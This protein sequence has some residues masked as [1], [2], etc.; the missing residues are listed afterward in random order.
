MLETKN[1]L[2]QFLLMQDMQF[3]HK[4]LFLLVK[5]RNQILYAMLMKTDPNILV[6]S[7][8][9]SAFVKISRIESRCVTLLN[10][11]KI[12]ESEICNYYSKYSFSGWIE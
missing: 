3:P 2:I 11:C 8:H 9:S 12:R 6:F 7:G 10:N 1:W 5:G 4:S